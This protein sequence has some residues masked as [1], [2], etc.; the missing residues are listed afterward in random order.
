MLSKKQKAVISKLN[1]LEKQ[2]TDA[3]ND[4]DRRGYLHEINKIFDIP[5]IAQTIDLLKEQISKSESKQQ[6]H[7]NLIFNDFNTIEKQLTAE[8]N[9]QEISYCLKISKLE[10][11][12]EK[13]KKYSSFSWREAGLR[14]SL[15]RYFNLIS[16]KKCGVGL[17]IREQVIQDTVD[18]ILCTPNVTAWQEEQNNYQTKKLVLQ[19]IQNIKRFN[20][21]NLNKND[22]YNSQINMQRACAYLTETLK[23]ACELRLLKI[24]SINFSYTPDKCIK[25]SKLIFWVNSEKPI[26]FKGLTARNF[27]KVLQKNSFQKVPIEEFEFTQQ[28]MNKN[29]SRRN[30]LITKDFKRIDDKIARIFNEYGF[31]AGSR[32]L[33]TKE[34]YYYGIEPDFSPF[35]KKHY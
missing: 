27:Y 17:F 19:S 7:E 23:I 12:K 1:E 2:I 3:T 22:L 10:G 5:L 25:N 30:H 15:I 33:I 4:K 6:T 29:L 28:T 34:I 21:K 9:N 20:E 13:S 24:K 14:V 8:Y 11:P 16:P 35:I 18:K 31:I 32:G 26:Y